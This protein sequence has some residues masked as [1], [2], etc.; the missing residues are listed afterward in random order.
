MKEDHAPTVEQK[1]AAA[2]EELVVVEKDAQREDHTPAVKQKR[3][4]AV[5]Q[6]LSLSLF[7]SQPLNL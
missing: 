2:A 4:M 5:E 7:L 1:H 6:K 3:A